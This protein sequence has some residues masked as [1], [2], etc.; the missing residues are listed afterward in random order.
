MRD[1]IFLMTG[2][3]LGIYPTEKLQHVWGVVMDATEPKAHYSLIVLADGTTSL[4]FSSGGGIIGAGAHPTIVAANHELMELA[5][6]LNVYFAV[7]GNTDL[8][9]A[10]YVRFWVLTYGGVK[11]L[12]AAE[13][14]LLDGGHPL[15]G[16]FEKA[17]AVITEIRHQ[18]ENRR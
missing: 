14:A 9:P 17:Q 15:S 5:E 3:G 18:S 1:K 13:K 12:E 2:E 10:G 16:L 6:S 11:G 7:A 4:Y 8:P